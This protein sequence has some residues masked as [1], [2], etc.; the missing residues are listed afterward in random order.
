VRRKRRSRSKRRKKG[1]QEGDREQA[2]EDERC[3]TMFKRM[4]KEK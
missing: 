4:R 1:G 2:G 3:K